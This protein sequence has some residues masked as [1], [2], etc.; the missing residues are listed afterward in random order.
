LS[1]ARHELT[2]ARAQNAA[3]LAQLEV[4]DPDFYGPEIARLRGSS[5]GDRRHPD[6]QSGD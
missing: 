2:I 3:L 5:F 4:R 6:F 1:R